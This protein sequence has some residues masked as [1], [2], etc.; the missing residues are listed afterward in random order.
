M[1]DVNPA[2]R[3]LNVGVIIHDNLDSPLIPIGRTFVKFLVL[4]NR[5]HC[6]HPNR[7]NKGRSNYKSRNLKQEILYFKISEKPFLYTI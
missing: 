7:A 5:T 3:F 1:K 2:A 4:L 6:L